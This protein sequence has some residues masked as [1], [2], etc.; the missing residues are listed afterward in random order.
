VEEGKLDDDGDNHCCKTDETGATSNPGS[1]STLAGVEAAS[2]E[3]E[4]HSADDE[5]QDED[6]D[7]D[8]DE[9]DELEVAEETALEKDCF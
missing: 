2:K 8:E 1:S 6:E 4:V 9:D 7:E 5:D 3:P